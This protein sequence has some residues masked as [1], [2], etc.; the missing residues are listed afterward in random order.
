MGKAFDL[1]LQIDVWSSFPDL[2]AANWRCRET[3]CLQE[4]K[5]RMVIIDGSI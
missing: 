5:L 2:Q 3:G 4:R 1:I